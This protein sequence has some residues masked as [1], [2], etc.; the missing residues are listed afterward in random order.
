M[1]DGELRE[2]CVG[3]EDHGFVWVDCDPASAV[4]D[5]YH[6]AQL[7]LDDGEIAEVNLEA[8]SFVSQAASMIENDQIDILVDLV[9]HMKGNRL[10]VFA[11]KPT[12]IQVTAW[13]E[14]TGTGLKAIDY[15]FADPVVVPMSERGLLAEHVADLPNFIGFWSPE[16]L[17]HP[18]PLPAIERGMLRSVRSI[19]SQRSLI[20]FCV[21][22]PGSY[23]QFP[24]H[25]L[26]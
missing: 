10:R 13:G 2:L 11:L 24:T 12:P 26:F 1:R 8:E 19:A 4:V 22:G 20:R 21:C 16:A 23:V 3:I 15:L 18:G 7:K 17:P 25:A 5:Y 14:P 9:G 6:R